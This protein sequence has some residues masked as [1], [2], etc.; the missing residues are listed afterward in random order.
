M[1]TL[2]QFLI[3]TQPLAQ[4]GALGFSILC[5]AAM[6]VLSDWR[7]ALAAYAGLKLVAGVLFTQLIPPE[8]ALMQWIVGGMIGLMWYLSC[9]RVDTEQR[10]QEGV[11][12]WRPTWHLNPSTYLRLALVLLILLILYSQRPAVTLPKLPA[13]LARLASFL[14]LAGVVGLG[15][16]DRPLRWGFGLSM[17][18]LGGSLVIN[19]LQVDA[20]MVGLLSGLEL[21]LGF[22]ISYL[23][24]GDGARFW[25]DWERR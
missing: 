14:A 16:G 17:W 10:R 22:A 23:I 3:L 6:L 20:R 25:P 19:A 12:W 7:L 21:L 18:V 24:V 9:R 8:W 5:A 1:P 11:P 2:D 4:R 15:F 13:D